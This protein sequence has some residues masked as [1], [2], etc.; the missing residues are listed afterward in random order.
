[1]SKFT[2]KKGNEDVPEISTATLPDIVFML[3][4]FFMVSTT[5]R[6]TDLLL[7]NVLPKA[8]QVTKLEKKDRVMFI[9]MGKPS[10]R[11][12]S[13]YGKGDK[14]QLNDRLSEVSEIRSFV[15][16]ERASRD[17]ALEKVLTASLKVDKDTKMGIVGDVKQELRKIEQY[18]VNY[19]TQKGSVI[20]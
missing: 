4:F 19:T 6:D 1:M 7:Q 9:F 13:T 20:E 5:M 2:K 8:D 3:L 15:L 14:I 11:Y 10:E 16:A 17:P 18:K 12:Q